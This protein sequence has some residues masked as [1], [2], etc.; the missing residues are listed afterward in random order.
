MIKRLQVARVRNEAFRII[1]RRKTAR[2]TDLEMDTLDD[3]AVHHRVNEQLEI[4]SGLHLHHNTDGRLV[5]AY[6]SAPAH[7]P[8]D[9]R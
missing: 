6:G 2:I 8:E 3:R 7:Y 9:E 5:V 1:L 4:W